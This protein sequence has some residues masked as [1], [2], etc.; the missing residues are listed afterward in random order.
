[1]LGKDFSRPTRLA[2]PQGIVAMLAVLLLIGLGFWPGGGQDREPPSR[3]AVAP[4]SV[5]YPEDWATTL[6]DAMK[7]LP[8]EILIP[9]HPVA[10][11]SNLSA[12]FV[13]PDDSAVALQF[14]PPAEAA[15]PLR[16]DYIEVWESTWA[17]GDPLESFNQDVRQDPRR[18]SQSST[19]RESQPSA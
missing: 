9:N 3:I 15:A 10:S 12:V 13:Y 5:G 8:F 16:Q 1:M 11:E 17:G 6:D 7:R 14:P 4:P 19:S 2:T 18:A